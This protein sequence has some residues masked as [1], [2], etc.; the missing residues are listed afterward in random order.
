MKL[1]LINPNTTQHITERMLVQSRVAAGTHAEVHGV[2]SSFGAAIIGSRTENAIA[3]HA[4]LD[5]AANHHAGFDAV[6]LGVSM[7]TA[8]RPMREMLDI[9]VVGMAE[10]ALLTSCMLGGR[11]G[12]LTLGGH[13]LPLYEE[14]TAAYGLQ[15][16]VA[17][18]RALDLPGA[19]GPDVD[20][21]VAHQIRAACETM[22][23]DDGAEV[24]VLCGAVLTGYAAKIAT[25]LSVPVIDCIEVATRQAIVLAEMRLG[26]QRAGSYS[27][28]TGR[29]LDG[30]GTELTRWL[31]G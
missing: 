11:I 4:A 17:C 26:P 6:I 20:I 30:M 7:D 14:L 19:Y 1:L 31:A 8:L 24:L 15:S 25:T 23:S 9:P 27:R 29:R 3:A 22:V 28:P 2:T 21:E 12:C 13:L 5:L 10:A 16:R 18:W